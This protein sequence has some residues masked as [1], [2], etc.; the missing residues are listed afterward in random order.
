MVSIALIFLSLFTSIK[1]SKY[2]KFKAPESG[3][4]VPND[5]EKP[6]ENPPKDDAQKPVVNPPNFS[7]GESGVIKR[8]G[9]NGTC[10]YSIHS[11]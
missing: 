9:I 10:M 11:S 2:F 1:K 8:V 7:G 5:A 4:D 3:K 6:V